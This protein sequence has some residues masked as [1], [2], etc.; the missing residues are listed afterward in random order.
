M[1][2]PQLFSTI[3]PKLCLVIVLS[4]NCIFRTTVIIAGNIRDSGADQGKGM[5]RTSL[6]IQY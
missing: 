3:I 4:D 1:R 5:I 6:V 2:R